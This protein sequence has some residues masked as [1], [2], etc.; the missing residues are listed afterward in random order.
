MEIPARP[1]SPTPGLR[2]PCGDWNNHH[3][4][5]PAPQAPCSLGPAAADS[6][7]VQ[8]RPALGVTRRYYHSQAFAMAMPTIIMMIQLVHGCSQLVH[9]CSQL[10]SEHTSANQV[11]LL[12]FHHTKLLKRLSFISYRQLRKEST[13]CASELAV[14]EPTPPAPG[15]AGYACL[16]LVCPL[17][18]THLRFPVFVTE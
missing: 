18:P 14:I 15:G 7:V 1:A 16:R 9:G 5:P 10:E 6:E 3:S 8:T 12:F 2:R 13:L 17:S 11:L 4:T